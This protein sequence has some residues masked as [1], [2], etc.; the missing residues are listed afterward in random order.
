[1]KKQ[2]SDEDYFKAHAFEYGM[3]PTDFDKKVKLFE[4]EFKIVGLKRW[5]STLPILIEDTEN[6][7]RYGTSTQKV[8]HALGRV[9]DIDFTK[10]SK[11]F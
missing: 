8:K 9:S 2:L 6:G 11:L 7:C 10:P 5:K 4:R 1:M 3:K